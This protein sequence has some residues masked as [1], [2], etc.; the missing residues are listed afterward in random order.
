MQVYSIYNESLNEN[1]Q[2]E[3]NFSIVFP[4][5]NFPFNR[6]LILFMRATANTCPALRLPLVP[7]TFL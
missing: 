6:Y 1:L 7:F 3:S 5:W 2:P 4:Q